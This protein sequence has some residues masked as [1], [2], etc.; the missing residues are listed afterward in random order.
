MAE[1]GTRTVPARV[2]SVLPRAPSSHLTCCPYWA[3]PTECVVHSIG[4]SAMS[5]NTTPRAVPPSARSRTVY[6]SG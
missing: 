2:T 1:A 4:R 3:H 5:C 6:V